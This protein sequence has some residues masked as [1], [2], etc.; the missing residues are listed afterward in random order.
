MTLNYY[1]FVNTSSCVYM[2]IHTRKTITDNYILQYSSSLITQTCLSLN[3]II[4]VIIYNI[5][6]IL[7][8]SVIN[9]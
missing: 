9:E 5:V 7:Y 1:D 8:S 3:T 2:P 6:L 4:V